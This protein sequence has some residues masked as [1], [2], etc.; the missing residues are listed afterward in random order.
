MMIIP[1]IDLIN[2]KCVRLK[3]GDYNLI[4]I[5]NDDPV[6][7]GTS[8]VLQGAKL[9]HVVDLEG[10]KEGSIKNLETI[11]KMVENDLKIEV[12]GGIRKMEDIDNLLSLGVQRVILGS[13]AVTDKNLLKNALK[14]YGP[15]KIVLGIDV[16]DGFVAIKGWI[17]KSKVK[18]ENLLV[19]YKKMGGKYVIYTDISKDGM[20]EGTNLTALAELIPY[21]LSIIASGGISEISDLVAVQ[22]IGCVGAIVGKAIYT[23]HISLEEAIGVVDDVR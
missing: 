1:A 16:K 21:G 10:A 23:N 11:K 9:I 22:S 5:Y 15:E 2:G 17:V 13:V 14:K 4:T 6:K 18:A 8:F 19:K 12:G 3:Q 20:L 7:V